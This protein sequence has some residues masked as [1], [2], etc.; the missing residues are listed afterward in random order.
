MRNWLRLASS[1]VVVKQSLLI[2]AIV[3]TLLVA[4]NHGRALLNGEISPGR[5]AQIVLTVVVPY[6]VSTVSSVGAMR[7]ARK[8]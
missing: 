4:V 1:P 5:I 2:A 6:C 8:P 3:G 7:A